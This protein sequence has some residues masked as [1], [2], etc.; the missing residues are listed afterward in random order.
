MNLLPL[1]KPLA[2]CISLRSHS[3]PPLRSTFAHCSGVSLTERCS[4]VTSF[5]GLPRGRFVL[6]MQPIIR[7]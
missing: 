2:R 7:D 4:R 3:N 5:G 6:S 1:Y